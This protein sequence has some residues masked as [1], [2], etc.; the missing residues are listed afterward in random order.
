M[1]HNPTP[2]HILHRGAATPWGV[3]QTTCD[4]APGIIE[5]STVSHGGFYLSP[6]RVAK[7]RERFPE[8]TSR[9]GAQWYEED[10]DCAVVALA[11]AE[12]FPDESIR[13]AIR[14]V[15]GLASSEPHRRGKWGAIERWIDSRAGE[16]LRLR[17]ARFEAIAAY[18]W[19]RG[20]IS[21]AGD[22]WTVNLRQV[23]S[24]R[25]RVVTMRQYPEKVFYASEE[26]DELEIRK[27]CPNGP[28]PQ[29]LQCP[30]R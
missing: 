8:F 7:I 27:D 15:R 5:V 22:G 26:L 11:H 21:T 14:T 10:C 19:E 2:Y 28:T 20:W 24:G 3:A 4:I 29:S 17:H 16:R 25:G 9:A 13:A 18:L 30:P 1:M 6:A 23:S 12:E